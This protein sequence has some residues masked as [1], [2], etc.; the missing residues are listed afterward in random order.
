MTSRFTRRGVLRLAAALG[1]SPVLPT[2]AGCGDSAVQ[3]DGASLPDYSFDGTPGPED[4]FQH[5]VASGDPLPDAVILWTRLTQDGSEPLDVFWEVAR[6]PGFADRVGAGWVVSDADRDF[7]VKLDAVGLDA[8]TT[9]YYRFQSLG[10]ASVVGR[11]RTAPSG[12]ADRVRL[13]V[14]SCSNYIGGYFHAY[15]GIAE[16]PD[17]D[18][19]LHLGD[20]IYEYGSSSVRAH[21]PPYEIVRLDDYRRRYAQYRSDLDLQEAHRQHPFVTVWDDHE[22]ANDAW[23][24]GASAHDPESEGGW[25]ERR[26]AA[27][28]AYS[29][30]MPIRDQADGR[31]FRH[32]SFGDLFDL[33]MLDTRIWGRDEQIEE[34]TD[35]EGVRDPSRTML[36]FDQ[37]DWLH[38]RLQEST[39]RW[40]IAGQQVILSPWKLGAGPESEGGGQ[41]A[42]TDAWDG[43]FP[44]R[45][46]L[47]QSLRDA[48]E[49]NFIVLTGDVHSSWAFDLTEDPNDPA[50]YDPD[51]GA[52]SLGVE[53]VTPGVT[54]GFPVP[55]QGFLN[56]LF[57]ANP[58][59][60][61]G[62]TEN[63]GYTVI[64]LTPDRAE[65]AWYH[66][67][68]ILEETA[69]ER[70]A[71]VFA[72]AAGTNHIEEQAE[73]A[74]APADPP[75]PAP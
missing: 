3:G 16:R 6:D 69:G 24:G 38:E 19:V 33:V 21:D 72:V 61:W 17:L 2:L 34:I 14:A 13:A 28:R 8:A 65:A 67:D 37:E 53:F 31:I 10:R 41:I 1:I 62:D 58:H 9:Y 27:G 25:A 59:L 54:S 4:L 23:S 32:L 63:R 75:A 26:A 55:G 44:A 20:Y 47:L 42:N 70:L 5:G 15:R 66:V 74:P 50:S 39:A 60:K 11:T 29:E 18:L 71:A 36:G 64:D 57:G 46:R 40:V 43:Y 7:T 48:G 51:T 56:V 73:P 45:S 35:R 12:P 68:S 30:W 52:G 22:T 49:P